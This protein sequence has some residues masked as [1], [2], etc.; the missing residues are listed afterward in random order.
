[1]ELNLKKDWRLGNRPLEPGGTLEIYWLKASIADIRNWGSEKVSGLHM[2]KR[3]RTGSVDL[4][5]LVLYS[6]Y[7]SFF[8][9]KTMDL[10]GGDGKKNGGGNHIPIGITY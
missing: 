6:L 4:T 2:T 8:D 3:I 1:M 9:T 5:H 7:S 10:R